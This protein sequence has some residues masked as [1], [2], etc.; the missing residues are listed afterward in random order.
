MVEYIPSIQRADAVMKGVIRKVDDL[1]LRFSKMEK[2][3]EKKTENKKHEGT[4]RHS[5]VIDDLSNNLKDLENQLKNI[6]RTQEARLKEEIQSLTRSFEQKLDKYS[7]TTENDKFN[8]YESISKKETQKN[9]LI[10]TISNLE[11]VK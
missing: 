10:S 6:N 4:E 7:K 8:S 1:E 11:E 3:L 2:V 9:A 5:K